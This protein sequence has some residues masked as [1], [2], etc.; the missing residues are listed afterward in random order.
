MLFCAV[1][2]AQAQYVTTSN[3]KLIW[4]TGSD[5]YVATS[6][7][8][9]LAVTSGHAFD[10]NTPITEIGRRNNETITFTK[11]N[12]LYVWN[13]SGYTSTSNP[14]VWDLEWNLDSSWWISFDVSH[15]GSPYNYATK[16]TNPSYYVTGAHGSPSWLVISPAPIPPFYPAEI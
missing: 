1:S 4:F 9:N 14:G 2:A 11:V 10:H 13:G 12:F 5:V 8:G 16:A 3:S 6:N 15:P 7:L